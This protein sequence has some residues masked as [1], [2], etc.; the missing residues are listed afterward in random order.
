[1][2]A[3]ARFRNRRRH[4]PLMTVLVAAGLF[5][6]RL[7]AEPPPGEGELQLSDLD[8]QART[9]SP[10][11]AGWKE[12]TWWL[13]AGFERLVL[14]VSGGVVVESRDRELLE[15]AGRGSPWSLNQL[16]VV[17]A[18]Y[19]G[20][21]AVVIVPW[22]HY[23]ELLVG[24][25][26]GVKFTFPPGREGATPGELVAVLTEDDPLAP[27]RAFREWRRSATR[28]G[29]VPALRPL[30][31]KALERPGVERLFGAAHF[32]LWGPVLFS[33]HDVARSRWAEWAR[34]LRDSPA[35]TAGAKLWE[36]LAA[37]ARSAFLELAAGP[38][39]AESVTA[40]A[41][42][43]VDRALRDATWLELPADLPVPEVIRRNREALAGQYGE[44]LQPAEAWGDG[45]S[46]ALVDALRNDGIRRAVLLLSDLHAA[47]PRPELASY[48]AAAGF[49]L[50]PYDSYHSV[51]DPEA[52]SDETWE[53]AQFDREAYVRGRILDADGRGRAGFR[54]RGFYFSPVAAWPWFLRR[55]GRL[56]AQVPYSA[57][58]VD[59]DAA[60]ELFDDYHPD[61][62]ATRLDDLAARRRR[63][64]WLVGRGFVVGSEDAS[65]LLSDV[66]DFGH[67]VQTPYLGHLEPLLSDRD[68]PYFLGRYWPP[69]G[70]ARF[71]AGVPVAP[72]LLKPYF[73]PR[74]RVPLLRAAFGDEVV[75]SHHWEFDTLKL[76]DV[77]AVRELM[78]ILY[79]TAP[80][81]HVNRRHW[82][83]RRERILRHLA[84]WAPLHEKLATAPL[85][86]FEW[87]TADRLVQRT[88]FESETGTVRIT[89]NFDTVE[90]EGLSPLSARVEG[91]EPK[92]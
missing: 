20:R 73:D 37:D 17:G 51:H 31:R 11:A 50:G 55:V 87:L 92:P 56:A 9:F 26:V 77:A 47:S 70:P 6:G 34:A 52:P 90:R 72:S 43:G 32:Y 80:L 29:G 7:A 2:A 63:L 75:M 48:A 24:E 76:N 61:H 22:P 64:E 12:W 79:M 27:A 85:A 4:A 83:L 13:P 84:V 46:R 65:A 86:R 1:M 14:P 33:R 44:F 71:F 59:C 28:R 69:E 62:P 66:V 67:G 89:A 16:P 19:G 60:G 39:E 54:G 18:S 8:R 41:A 42:A 30:A 57:W 23:A 5:L 49:L 91:M 68:S 35:G 25:R 15:W 88:T 81:Y 38:H 21:M 82:P 58:F 78:E 74:V 45:P 3:M 36:G 40:R 10:E 53:T